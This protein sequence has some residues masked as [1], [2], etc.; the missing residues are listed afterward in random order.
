M[1]PF[2][3]ISGLGEIAIGY[4]NQSSHLGRL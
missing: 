1:F 3:D 4:K 2:F